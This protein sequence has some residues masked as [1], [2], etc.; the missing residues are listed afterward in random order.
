MRRCWER[1]GVFAW[2]FAGVVAM[3]S[4]AEAK[5]YYVSAAG[6]DNSSGLSASAPWKTLSRVNKLAL[7]AGDRILLR[8]GDR[9]P[10]RLYFDAGE[11]GSSATPIEVSSYGKGRATILA[12]EGFGIYA[13]NT[14]GLDIS[15]LRVLG[16]GWHSSN[17][18]GIFFYTD[19]PRTKLDF[20]SIADVEVSGFRSGIEIGASGSGGYK[21]V[22]ISDVRA[23]SNRENGI[24]VWGSD[25]PGHTGYSHQNVRITRAQAYM[26]SGIEKTGSG[27]VL[28]NVDGGLI[29]RSVAHGNG[30]RLQFV[31]SS[32]GPF[33]IWAWR[34]NR[35]VIQH[36]ESYD[37]RSTIGGADGGGFDLDG[38]VTNSVMQYNYSHGNDGAGYLLAQY[39]GALPFRNNVVRFNISENDGRKNF[40]G[41]INIWSYAPYGIQ[42]AE[43]YN[44]TI[45]MEPSRLT[46]NYALAV[47]SKTANVSLRN[48][49]LVTTG[50]AALMNVVSGQTGMKI[51][52]NAYWPSGRPFRI[53]WAGNRYTSLA[54]FRSTGQERLG[55]AIV[56]Y[57]ENP[58]FIDPGAGITLNNAD[59]LETLA[60]YKLRPTSPL[61]NK[62]LNLPARFG[63][64]VGRRDYYGTA[65]SSDDA[66]FAIGA[67]ARGE[68][69]AVASR[70]P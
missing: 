28:S 2:C 7:N 16:S 68:E 60:G 34:A 23:H 26:N 48:N 70:E 32:G 62:G 54:A 13:F 42:E 18:S 20:V 31:P 47:W 19:L 52:G 66:T 50:G 6:S 8:G 9:F 61:I 43:I 3:S 69:F 59:R 14:A 22:K 25:A 40:Y 35:I 64:S 17:N 29:E 38:G 67:H 24:A 4:G 1:A 55:T 58:E 45:Y 53:D 36:N 12:G 51:Q 27:I 49:I 57:S 37:N 63:I 21:N 5:S 46:T 11:R 10:G 39:K 65:V 33:G 56:G 30:I 41:G 15:D 44:N